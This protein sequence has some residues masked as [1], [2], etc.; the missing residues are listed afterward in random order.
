MDRLIITIFCYVDDFLKSLSRQDDKQ[1]R[2]T[3]AEIITSPSLLQ[4]ASEATSNLL[5]FFSL[6]MAIF[7]AFTRAVSTDAFMLF[8]LSFGILSSL[9]SPLNT[10]PNVLIS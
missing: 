3:L 1:C 9:T 2:F 10:T 7:V 5:E 4:C 8:L 6:S